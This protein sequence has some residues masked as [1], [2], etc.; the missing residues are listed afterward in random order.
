MQRTMGRDAGFVASLGRGVEHSRFAV[1]PA[2]RAK[3]AGIVTW[4]IEQS[5]FGGGNGRGG[6]VVEA[7]RPRGSYLDVNDVWIIDYCRTAIGLARAGLAASRGGTFSP[8]VQ[9]APRQIS[10][11][12]RHQPPPCLSQAKRSWRGGRCVGGLVLGVLW[13]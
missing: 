13:C 7:E 6:V 1:W 9:D 8:S 11:L 2:R 4:E 3:E 5:P 12:S 10:E